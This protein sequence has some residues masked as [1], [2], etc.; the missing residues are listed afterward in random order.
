M[1]VRGSTE[2]LAANGI[3][4]LKPRALEKSKSVTKTCNKAIFTPA[5]LVVKVCREP[6]A[7]KLLVVR[8]EEVTIITLNQTFLGA[9]IYYFSAVDITL[10]IS[11]V[12]VGAESVRC[13]LWL[14]VI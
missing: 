13:I 3:R 10:R 5:D 7:E 1:G 14:D 12:S 4:R 11:P 6:I 9:D 8:Y 2:S